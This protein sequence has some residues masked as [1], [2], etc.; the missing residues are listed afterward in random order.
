MKNTFPVV[1]LLIACGDDPVDS[2]EV[3]TETIENQGSACIASDSDD[4]A[5]TALVTVML[6]DCLPSC[7]WGEEATCT[8]STE[9]GIVTVTASGTYAVGYADPT[10]DCPSICIPLEASCEA[11]GLA[12][13]KFALEYAGVS[14]TFT[15]PVTETIC[16]TP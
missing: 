14:A 1:L 5:D 8:A 9:D 13:G 6:S 2:G 12:K 16:T 11:N 15:G 4:N 3:S 10:V 7:S